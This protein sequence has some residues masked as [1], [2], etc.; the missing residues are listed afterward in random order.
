[1]KVHDQKRKE[2]QTSAVHC[3]SESGT[4]C[5]S[6]IYFFALALLVL[7]PFSKA[8]SQNVLEDTLG[9]ADANLLFKQQALGGIT[10]HTEGW[11]FFFRRARIL[12]I[13]RKV[14]W[15]AEAVTMHDQHEYKIAD[16]N[17]PNA[18]PYYFG[19]LNGMETIRIGVGSMQMLWRKNDLNCTQIDAVYAAGLSVAILK[20]VYLEI[21][22]SSP[23]GNDLPVAQEYNPNTDTP[24]NIYGRASV[25]DGFGQLAFYPGGY[26]R[27]GLNFDFSN[28]H[29]L[30]KALELGVIVD[31]YDKVIPMMAFT[32]NNQAFINLYA[33]FSLGKRW[34]DQ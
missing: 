25:F 20:P 15:E 28:R 29:Q 4:R 12:S 14:F 33:S 23:N 1:M 2:R 26:G 9:V 11:G 22:P 6:L 10:A 5:S 19:K 17:E 3:N 16:P 13:Y 34:A 7:L 21:I 27:A 18:T 24:S 8:R 31:V 30:V 32:K